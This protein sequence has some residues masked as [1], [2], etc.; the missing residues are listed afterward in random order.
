MS[1]TELGSIGELIAAVATIVTLLYL[2]MQIKANTTVTRAES[3]RGAASLRMQAL[4]SVTASS[5]GASVFT[6]GIIDPRQLDQGERAQFNFQFSAM[7][8]IAESSFFE[9]ELGLI[10][11]ATMDASCA[12]LVKLLPS[13]GGQDYWKHNSDSHIPAFREYLTDA[14]AI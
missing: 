11:R 3:Q 12:F 1:I 6:R 2:A 10:D 9:Y 14:V 13:P 8:S 7:T 5:Q 4:T